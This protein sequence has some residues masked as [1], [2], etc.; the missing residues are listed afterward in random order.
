MNMLLFLDSWG[1][2]AIAIIFG[3]L[4]TISMKLSHGL[5]RPKPVIYLAIFYTISF[6]ALT[7]AMKYIDLSVVYAVWS[8]VG[9]VLVAAIGIFYFN[10][11]IS[12]KK[13]VFLALIIVGVIGMHLSDG[14][15]T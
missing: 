4:G 15:Y 8:G 10:E 9:T 7:F 5:R 1:S 12:L 13:I 3:V 11:K 2:L 6:V 14:I